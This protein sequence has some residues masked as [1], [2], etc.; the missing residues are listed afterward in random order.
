[1][2]HIQRARS[3]PFR[4]PL[5]GAVEDHEARCRQHRGAVPHH[6]RFPAELDLR[7]GYQIGRY[8]RDRTNL[9]SDQLTQKRHEAELREVGQIL[10]DGCVVE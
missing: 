9:Q 7:A 5:H 4:Q 6:G 1:M 10:I 8:G 2:R 3:D